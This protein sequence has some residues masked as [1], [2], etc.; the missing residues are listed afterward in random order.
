MCSSAVT[1]DLE[2]HFLNGNL[3]GLVSGVGNHAS[4]NSLLDGLGHALAEHKVLE[5]AVQTGELVNQGEVVEGY[6][7]NAWLTFRNVGQDLRAVAV[8]I[9]DQI[10]Q[11]FFVD[12]K[13][14]HDHVMAQTVALVKELPIVQHVVEGLLSSAIDLDAISKKFKRDG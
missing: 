11:L 4:A 12:F 10:L 2:A 6:G 1:E 8:H 9:E 3:L 13:M 5:V 7:M 14:F